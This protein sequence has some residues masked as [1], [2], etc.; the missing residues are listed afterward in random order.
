LIYHKIRDGHREEGH[1]DG[2]AIL[3]RHAA[4]LK[5]VAEEIE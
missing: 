3:K 1:H 4:D 2:F 5:E